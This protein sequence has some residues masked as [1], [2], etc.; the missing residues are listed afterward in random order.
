MSRKPRKNQNR[1][2][3]RREREAVGEGGTAAV[4]VSSQG[5]IMGWLRERGP[6]FHFVVKLAVLMIVANVILMLDPVDE[7]AMPRYMEGW[8]TVSAATLRVMGIDAKTNGTSIYSSEPRF[9]VN[10]K[11]G[12]DAVQPM[13]LFIMAVLASPVLW[14]TKWMGL[15]AGIAFLMVMNLVRVISLYYTGIYWE[16]AFEIMHHDVWQTLFVILS[17]LA[18]L[19]WALWAVKKTARRHAAV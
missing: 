14:K 10:I 15:L 18:W 1:P 17:I 16:S 4:A 13:V 3:R 7:R 9:S 11:K 5:G 19:F 8:A 12:C 6:I 2:S